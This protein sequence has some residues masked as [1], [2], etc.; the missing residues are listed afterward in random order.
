VQLPG[1][2]AGG[3]R[4]RQENH[5]RGKGGGV[6]E[7]KLRREARVWHYVDGKRVEGCHS[8]IVGNVTGITGDVTGISGDVDA[9]GLTPEDRARGVNIYELVA[10]VRL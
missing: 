6:M 10:V 1:L 7:R 4:V 3:V 9:C 5:P 2:R 8:R